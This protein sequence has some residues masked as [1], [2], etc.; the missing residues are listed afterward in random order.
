MRND[1][2]DAPFRLPW[3]LCLKYIEKD[4]SIDYLF[5]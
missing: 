5:R 4:I 3:W 2:I 1:V